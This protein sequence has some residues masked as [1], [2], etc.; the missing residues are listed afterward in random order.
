MI[1]LILRSCSGIRRSSTTHRSSAPLILAFAELLLANSR[2]RPVM[3][4]DSL[5]LPDEWKPVVQAAARADQR[6]LSSLHDLSMMNGYNDIWGY[7]PGVLKRYSQLVTT[8]QG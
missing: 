8:A 1:R 3:L 5:E 6:V 7:D 4:V 2:A